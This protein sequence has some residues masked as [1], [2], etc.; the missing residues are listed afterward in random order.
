[1]NA[2][3]TFKAKLDTDYNRIK[4]PRFTSSHVNM[5]IMRS[6]PIYGGLV[7]SNMLNGMLDRAARKALGCSRTTQYLDINNLPDTV[8]I[9]TTGFLAKVTINI[10][11]GWK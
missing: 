9:D 1:M 6:H 2:V 10:E 3:I 8:T 4:F 11:G 5:A 7:N